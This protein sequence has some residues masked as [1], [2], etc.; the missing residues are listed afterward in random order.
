MAFEQLHSYNGLYRHRNRVAK[1]I[2]KFVKKLIA[3]FMTKVVAKFGQ[4][5]CKSF[6]ERMPHTGKLSEQKSNKSDLTRRAPK[7][8]SISND[9][10]LE[11]VGT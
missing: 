6:S 2:E 10:S 1:L 3:K 8:K 4:T 9:F 5:L 11:S 7:K